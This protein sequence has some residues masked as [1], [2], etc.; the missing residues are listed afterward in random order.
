[1]A[2]QVLLDSPRRTR[3]IPTYAEFPPEHHGVNDST[4]NPHYAYPFVIYRHRLGR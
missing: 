2:C 1:M 3:A 4:N